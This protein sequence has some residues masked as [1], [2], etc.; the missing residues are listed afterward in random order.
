MY[1]LGMQAVLYQLEMQ[2]T[3][4]LQLPRHRCRNTYQKQYIRGGQIC[5]M[6]EPHI[7]KPKLQRAAT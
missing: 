4:I 7:V 5:Y 3:K 6:Y 2:C 1:G